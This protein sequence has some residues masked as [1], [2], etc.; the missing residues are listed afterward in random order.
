[1]IESL[2]SAEK[3][4]SIRRDPRKN[5]PRV[6]L[7]VE[8][9]ILMSELKNNSPL[10]RLNNSGTHLNRGKFLWYWQEGNL[11]KNHSIIP[12]LFTANF[13][14]STAVDPTSS[15]CRHICLH[16]IRLR[17]RSTFG[18]QSNTVIL[19]HIPVFHQSIKWVLYS[20]TSN[21]I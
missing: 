4:D 20:S 11:H 9:S 5:R 19:L 2:G 12:Y 7:K 14:F 13:I 17:R 16:K 10:K 15:N 21:C 8:L 6:K 1:V 3:V 18:D